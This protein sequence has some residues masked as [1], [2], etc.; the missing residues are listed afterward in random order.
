MAKPDRG[1]RVLFTGI[2]GTGVRRSIEKLI[3]HICDKRKGGH[4]I[5]CFREV[6]R[7][8][9]QARERGILTESDRVVDLLNLP[10]KLL[11]DLWRTA[12]KQ[13][14]EEISGVPPQHDVF[15]SVHACYYHTGTQEYFT[16]VDERLLGQFQ[17][18]VVITLI[19][20]IYDV[21]WR[22][23]EPG[24]LYDPIPNVETVRHFE[25][26]SQI[27][28]WRSNE[29]LLTDHLVEAAFRGDVQAFVLAVKHPIATAE[30]LIYE[31]PERFFYLS[32][33]ISQPRRMQRDHQESDAEQL[34]KEVQNVADSLRQQGIV[35]EPTTI[36]E[37]RFAT[38]ESPEGSGKTK[39]PCLL[40]RWPMEDGHRLLWVPPERRGNPLDPE[41]IFASPDDDAVARILFDPSA[42]P[43]DRGV[44]RKLLTASEL[45]RHLYE[46]I[47]KQVNSRDHRLVEQSD[48]L[49]V[50]RPVFA[51]HS[52]DGVLQEIGYYRRLVELE[53]S[54]RSTEVFVL[55]LP[56]DVKAYTRA[57]AFEF[58]ADLP[59]SNPTAAKRILHE[60]VDR[61][62]P[63]TDTE[64]A[65]A[66][67]DKVWDA[68]RNAGIS[69]RGTESKPLS[70]E[71]AV[72]FQA[73]RQR[74]AKDLLLAVTNPPAYELLMAGEGVHI[75]EL[76]SPAQFVDKIAVALGQS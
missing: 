9:K 65:M 46:E 27:L 52:S 63:P 44:A 1:A 59:W 31:Q 8:L 26:L 6:P 15:V 71:P 12:F 39:I 41:G 53:L 5:H 17:P 11:R 30:R 47:G 32:H 43:G 49:V 16:T 58:L 67:L 29:I 10:H 56:E 70:P 28:Q 33:P 66:M 50:Y 54:E 73:D 13:I 37:L 72:Q 7:M 3:I 42:A 19:D 24:G 38:V 21:Y 40:K 36:D 48:C 25:R 68:M 20:D 60:L 34:I 76:L 35:F 18:D 62:A 14:L 75:K 64:G 2:S 45:V 4:R 74:L 61:E 51:G 22:L 55:S 57:E 69:L 23:S